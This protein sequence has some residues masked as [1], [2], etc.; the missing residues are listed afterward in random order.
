[1][2]VQYACAEL[3]IDEYGVMDEFVAEHEDML[4]LM[5]AGNSGPEW[6]VTLCVWS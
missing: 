4:V 6:Q 3:V 5:A 1:M 2:Q